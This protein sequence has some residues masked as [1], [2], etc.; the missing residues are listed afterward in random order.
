MPKIPKCPHCTYL[1][2]KDGSCDACSTILG[3]SM[4]NFYNEKIL[5]CIRRPLPHIEQPAVRCVYGEEVCMWNPVIGCQPKKQVRFAMNDTCDLST[6]NIISMLLMTAIMSKCFHF[7]DTATSSL[8]RPMQQS[9]RRIMR[10]EELFLETLRNSLASI[11]AS[12]DQ[13]LIV[14]TLCMLITSEFDK[15]IKG[16]S[17]MEEA[18]V[19][20]LARKMSKMS[21]GMVSIATRQLLSHYD[22][23]RQICYPN[24][25]DTSIKKI[26]YLQKQVTHQIRI[27]HEKRILAAAAIAEVIQAEQDVA[28]L[29]DRVTDA[30]MAKNDGISGIWESV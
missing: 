12:S 8:V 29:Q 2:Q 21:N 19:I 5:N 6:P 1:L 28:D 23:F 7:V 16:G 27:V 11:V 17:E 25:W 22:H 13:P 9:L 4:F 15:L 26:E 20:T 10:S 24:C 30:M 14:Q 18:P 3:V